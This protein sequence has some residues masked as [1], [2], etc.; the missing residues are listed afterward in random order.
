MVQHRLFGPVESATV[1]RAPV[2]Q[3]FAYQSTPRRRRAEVLRRFRSTK[4][5]GRRNQDQAVGF[6][7]QGADEYKQI[8]D[9][10]GIAEQGSS[11][12]FR[13]LAVGAKR[14]KDTK[15]PLLTACLTQDT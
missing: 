5:D 13:L 11:K 10:G 14:P 7:R 9:G 2:L 4:T 6:R 8:F 1:L 12:T 3:R 15:D